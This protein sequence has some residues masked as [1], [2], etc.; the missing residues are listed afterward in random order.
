MMVKAFALPFAVLLLVGPAPLLAQPAKPGP[1]IKKL[2]TWVGTWTY[3]GE[4][5]ATPLGAAAK[6]AGTETVRTIAGGFGLEWK[7]EEKGAFGAVQWSETD[8]F[9]PVTKTYLYFGVQNDGTLWSGSNTIVGN[10]WK[11]TGTQTVKGTRYQT[12]A[13]STLS[14]DGKS[15]TQKFELS[16][17]GKNWMPWMEI[18]MTKSARPQS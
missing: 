12:R 2:E 16:T 15:W 18:R 14:A 13:D 7:A 1:E 5:K 9:D 11:T 6:I 8:V 4:A 3:E 10:T 17:D